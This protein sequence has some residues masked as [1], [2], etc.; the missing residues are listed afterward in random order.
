MC[1][2][3]PNEIDANN[4]SINKVLHSALRLHVAA[5]EGTENEQTSLVK[6]TKAT[7]QVILL[8]MGPNN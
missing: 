1:V 5:P 4:P 3:C 7:S 8:P 2:G 6:V